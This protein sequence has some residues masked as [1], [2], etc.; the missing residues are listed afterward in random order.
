MA[1]NY[2]SD[3]NNAASLGSPAAPQGGREYMT[4]QPP[5]GAQSQSV[6]SSGGG[7]GAQRRLPTGTELSGGRY[8]IERPVAAGGMGAVYRAIDVRFSRPCAVKEMLDDF[9][10]DADRGQAVEWFRREATLLL[11]LNHP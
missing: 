2:P 8:K 9:Q 11:D 4:P 7:H 5:Y 1:S 6:S 10:N 3:P